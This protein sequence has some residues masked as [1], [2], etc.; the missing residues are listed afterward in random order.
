MATARGMDFKSARM[1]AHKTGKKILQGLQEEGMV[2]WAAVVG[3]GIMQENRL[4]R[5]A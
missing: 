3:G 1:E 2:T 5:L 4:C